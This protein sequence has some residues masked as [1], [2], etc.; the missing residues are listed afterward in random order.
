MCGIIGVLHGPNIDHNLKKAL[1]SFM[2]DAVIAGSV[3]GE[4][5]TG[6]FQLRQSG[7]K[8][9]AYKA[10]YNGHEF[11]KDNRARAIISSVD[12]SKITVAHHR[13]ATF[14]PA[15]ICAANAH[16]FEHTTKDRYVIGVHNGHI[17][18][19]SYSEDGKNFSVDSDWAMH[20]IAR[21]GGKK[22]IEDFEGAMVLVWLEG[23]G[24]LRI[25]GNGKRTIYWNYVKDLDVMIMTSEHEMMYWLAS[26]HDIP[27]EKTMWSV[28]EDRIYTFDPEKPR[29]IKTET[30]VPKKA[31]A[32]VRTPVLGLPALPP[33]IKDGGGN[34]PTHGPTSP[35]E[36]NGQFRKSYDASMEQRLK[37]EKDLGNTP[38]LR[39]V[40]GHVIHYESHN[41]TAMG[42]D[43][44]EEVEFFFNPNTTKTVNLIGD[45]ML[46]VTKVGN[47]G[48]FK[49]VAETV[50]A[51]VVGSSFQLRENMEQLVQQGGDCYCRVI[52]TSKVF[53]DGIEYPCVVLSKPSYLRIGNKEVINDKIDERNILSLKVPGPGG[54]ALSVDEFSAVVK[55]GCFKCKEPLYPKQAREGK[56]S[57]TK[58]CEPLCEK[59]SPPFVTEDDEELEVV[60]AEVLQQ[61]HDDAI[62]AGLIAEQN[63]DDVA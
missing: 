43:R 3:R 23:D 58:D 61:A 50:K 52:G 26:R 9:E 33:P 35:R 12:T 28:H 14:G 41:I 57:W 54:L 31:S 47:D 6:M 15:N 48:K 34:R 32:P 11:S 7:N 16:P 45:V 19:F 30:I 40:Q 63:K 27:L 18:N 56:I 59:C 13:A 46:T 10:P 20:R 62:T 25:Y 53:T 36:W 60:T 21:D 1:C 17:P 8:M 2:R 44:N 24:K 55:D 29:V 39:T 37:D 5:S 38:I 51:I 42:F 49:E 22:A 4:D